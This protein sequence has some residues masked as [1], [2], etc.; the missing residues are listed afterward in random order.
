MATTP[1]N[2]APTTKLY[3]VTATAGGPVDGFDFYGPFDDANDAS[4]WAFNELSNASWW[5]NELHSPT[6]PA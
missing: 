4:D 1:T 2:P 6:E 5:V 3:I